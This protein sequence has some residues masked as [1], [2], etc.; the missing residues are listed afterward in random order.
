MLNAVIIEERNQQ[1]LGFQF[2]QMVKH[3]QDV[4][5]VAGYTTLHVYVKIMTLLAYSYW[6]Y[7]DLHLPKKG[8]LNL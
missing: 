6:I 8:I 3:A 5:Q 4:L 7:S 2:G 1:I